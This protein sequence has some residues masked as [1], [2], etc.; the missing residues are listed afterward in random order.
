MEEMAGKY[1]QALVDR[2]LILVCKRS[3]SGKI[4]RCSM[5]QLLRDVCVRIA[6]THNFLHVVES[7]G[8][9]TNERPYS[10]PR[11]LSIHPDALHVKSTD[12]LWN[13]YHSVL[14]VLC[15]ASQPVKNPIVIF[16]RF[17][18]LLVLDVLQVH[19]VEF[20]RDIIKCFRLKY[21]ALHY[22]GS[23][24]RSISKLKY[25]Q[26]IVHHFSF[27]NYCLL[28]MVIWD[29]PSLRHLYMKPG[30]YLSKPF[31]WPFPLSLP[32]L[33]FL[34]TLVG[35]R[36][37]KWSK[38]IIGRIPNLK[39]LVISYDV[40][41]SV[42]WPAYQH[43]TLAYQHRL[44]SLKIIIK[45]NDDDDDDDVETAI[46]LDPPKL[47][48]PENLKKLCLKG[49]G[50]SSE[51]MTSI[52]KLSNLTALK[53]RCG[54]FS[55]PSWENVEGE[56]PELAFLLLGDLRLTTWL[57]DEAPFPRL[58]C[59]VIR[60]CHKLK[61]IPSTIGE[62]STLEKIKLVEKKREAGEMNLEAGGVFPGRM[63]LISDVIQSTVCDILLVVIVLAIV[64]R[65]FDL[66]TTQT[67]HDSDSSRPWLMY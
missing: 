44:E 40:S 59:L 11:R 64:F 33:P 65:M 36:N 27:R 12:K 8:C 1:L 34:Q 26:T 32:S 56:F 5:H 17:M 23:L 29:M 7:G 58:E 61:E 49:C 39:N 28:P 24:P 4:R 31:R 48:F 3:C 14:S 30:C 35:I 37:F 13:S 51:C 21:L 60:L 38:G 66:G 20:P 43:E 19:F 6:S 62:I 46:S 22:D 18:F 42:Y 9:V 55:G 15:I 45:Y 63:Q 25:L 16:S 54:A 52:G 50:V 47:E 53:L 2:N 57:T 10:T 41:S 67:K